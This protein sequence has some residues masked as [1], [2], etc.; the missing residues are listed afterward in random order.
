M[1]NL[2]TTFALSLLTTLALGAT[3]TAQAGDFYPGDSITLRGDQFGTSILLCRR[4]WRAGSRIHAGDTTTF[5]CEGG[6][7][8]LK[9]GDRIGLQNVNGTYIS[10]MR[11]KN[12]NAVSRVTWLGDWEYFTI[13]DANGNTPNVAINESATLP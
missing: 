2:T 10:A 8:P 6:S 4:R 9:Y 12:H 13:V 11:W 7:G 1:K 5:R 3:N